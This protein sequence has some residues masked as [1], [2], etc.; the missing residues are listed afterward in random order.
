MNEALSCVRRTRRSYHRL[1][2]LPDSLLRRS[3]GMTD[4][5]EHDVTSAS[6]AIGDSVHR[7]EIARA[8]LDKALATQRNALKQASGSRLPSG[9]ANFTG[10][11]RYSPLLAQI[12]RNFKAGEDA[13]ATDAG[14]LRVSARSIVAS[15]SGRSAA[16]LG[17]LRKDAS[18]A[19]DSRAK[20]VTSFE[21]MFAP[22]GLAVE[23]V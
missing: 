1:L 17:V 18:S 22:S 21:A 8:A 23:P 5:L 9:V 20:V 12:I 13:M 19:R 11:H 7:L 10:S 3:L 6:K 2:E 16:L 4:A 15:L 14:S